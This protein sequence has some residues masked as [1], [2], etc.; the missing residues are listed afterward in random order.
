MLA[1]FSVMH[2]VSTKPGAVQLKHL[3]DRPKKVCQLGDKL[4]YQL[5]Y[6]SFLI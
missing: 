2:S 4:F 5:L 6:S 3:T 1:F